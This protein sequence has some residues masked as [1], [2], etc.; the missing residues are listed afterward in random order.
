MFKEGD[1]VKV[2]NSSIFA[3]SVKVGDIGT[4]ILSGK[5]NYL[6]HFKLFTQSCNKDVWREGK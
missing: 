3:P 2:I 5:E 1:R 6:L 4:I